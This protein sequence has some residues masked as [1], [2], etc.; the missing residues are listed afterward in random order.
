MTPSFSK[1]KFPIEIHVEDGLSFTVL[2]VYG[3]VKIG[4]QKITDFAIKMP[5]SDHET[6]E[7]ESSESYATSSTNFSS[8]SD[9]SSSTESSELETDSDNRRLIL[10]NNTFVYNFLSNWNSVFFLQIP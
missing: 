4:V 6:S 8:E 7:S 1:I 10:E 5:N 3:M 9:S 2:V